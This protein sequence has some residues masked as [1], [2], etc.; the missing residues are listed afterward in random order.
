MLPTRRASHDDLLRLFSK[1][2]PHIFKDA[3][4]PVSLVGRDVAG[5]LLSPLCKSLESDFQFSKAI[6][7]C[8]E[9]QLNS[10]LRAA[11]ENGRSNFVSNLIEA[12]AD[13]VSCSDSLGGKS[14]M[15]L[16]V[17]SGKIESVRI[18]I[19]SGYVIDAKNDLFLHVAAAMNRVD[20]ME[21]MCL[22]YI[23][24]DLNAGDEQGRTPLHL[25]AANGQ[26]EAIQFLVSVGS[27]GD[28]TDQDGRT[29]LHFAAEEGHL[30]AVERLLGHAVF[31]KYAVDREGKTA[32]ALAVERG[33][34]HLY[35]ALRLGDLLQRAARIDDVHTMKSCLAQGAKV[36]GFDQNGW[37]PL[38][39]AAFKGHLESV[40]LL[41][42]HGARVDSVDG[43]GYT[44]L[45][46]AVE[47]GHVEVA[48]YLLSHGAKASLKSL[49]GMVKSELECFKNHPSLVNPITQEKERA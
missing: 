2:G 33:N 13:V 36:N 6:S 11:V 10:L 23:D 48:M 47:A 37:T 30:D 29:P 20:M 42:S 41:L 27:D 44:P 25:A 8:D 5:F 3:T 18:L 7:V 38:H 31:A 1:L 43:S 40:R 17:E 32:F 28:V 46:R 4:I 35:D 19:E 24:I 26:V 12:G 16:A 34:S 15:C 9:S 45:L 39:R 14:L 49:R 21:I 22:S